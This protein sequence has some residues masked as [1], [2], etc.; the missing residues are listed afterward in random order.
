M[1]VTIFS[2]NLS[3]PEHQRLSV[4]VQSEHRK[5][6]LDGILKLEHERFCASP[7]GQRLMRRRKIIFRKSLGSRLVSCYSGIYIKIQDVTLMIL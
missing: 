5:V 4:E 2:D 6:G 7:E 3:E 1:E